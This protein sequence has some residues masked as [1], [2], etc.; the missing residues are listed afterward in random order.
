VCLL[1]DLPEGPIEA[2]ARAGF[3]FFGGGGDDGVGEAVEGAELVVG[4]VQA[5]GIVV[6]PG[7]V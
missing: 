4:A 2:D 7:F 1:Y 5:P 6:R 3:D